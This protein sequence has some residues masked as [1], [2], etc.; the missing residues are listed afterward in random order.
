MRRD[1]LWCKWC[2]FF[3]RDSVVLVF[4]GRVRVGKSRGGFGLIVSCSCGC[5]DLFVAGML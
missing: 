4:P 1:S 5:S 3:A 2:F